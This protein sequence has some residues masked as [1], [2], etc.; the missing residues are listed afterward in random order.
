MTETDVRSALRSIT[1]A[2][3]RPLWRK[4]A[5]NKFEVSPLTTRSQC[6]GV[7]ICNKRR[8]SKIKSAPTNTLMCIDPVVVLSC[9]FRSR[10]KRN[11]AFSGSVLKGKLEAKKAKRPWVS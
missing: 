1:R 3:V 6:N 8:V 7:C 5:Q 2:S 11:R 4:P 9:I 10:L